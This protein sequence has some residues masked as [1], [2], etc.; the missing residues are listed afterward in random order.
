MRFLSI[1]MAA[2]LAVTG[3]PASGLSMEASAAGTTGSGN[4]LKAIGINSDVAPEGFDENDTESNPYG[5]KTVV[6]TVS[7]EVYV[8]QIGEKGSALIGNERVKPTGTNY[9]YENSSGHTG[10]KYLLTYKDDIAYDANGKSYM[11]HS[12]IGEIAVSGDTKADLAKSA[13]SS[14]GYTVIDKDLND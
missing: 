7:D 14:Q 6:G 4:A 8:A 11:N 13:L 3:F 12:Y 1:M 9:S 5:K 2:T 10:G